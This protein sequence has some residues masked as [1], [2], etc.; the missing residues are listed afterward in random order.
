MSLPKYKELDN[1]QTLE[2]I[3]QEIFILQKKQIL[4]IKNID[5]LVLG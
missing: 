1:L 2:D 5:R 3:D 4:Q